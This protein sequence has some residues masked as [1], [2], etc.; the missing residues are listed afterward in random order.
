M[1]KTSVKKVLNDIKKTAKDMGDMELSYTVDTPFLSSVSFKV[2][3]SVDTSGFETFLNKME[4]AHLLA[5]EAVRSGVADHLDL[6][7]MSVWGTGRDI[8]DSAEL[9]TS[10]SVF[11]NGDDI[12]ITYTSPYASLVHY[13]GYV[14][15]Y[16]NT[17]IEKVYIPGRPWVAA[18]LGLAPGPAGAYDYEKQYLMTFR[19]SVKA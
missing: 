4:E 5:M 14:A 6:Q 1:T 17:S 8:V 18:T 2:D 16:G 15:P 19:S 10:A 12:T 7:M 13:G 9:L 3:R 11:L